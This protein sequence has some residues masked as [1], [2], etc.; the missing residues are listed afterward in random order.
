MSI[1]RGQIQLPG[2]TEVHL[3][4]QVLNAD[5][6]TMPRV[7]LM[8][9]QYPKDSSGT[10]WKSRFDTC[11][12]RLQALKNQY[13]VNFPI[14]GVRIVPKAAAADFMHKLFG[15]TLGSLRAERNRLR[16]S[17]P[18]TAASKIE[19]LEERIRYTLE[20]WGNIPTSDSTP[21]YDPNTETQSIAY[22]FWTAVREFVSN[23]TD[24]VDQIR[25][26]TQCWDVVSR[27]IPQSAKAML[28][29]FDL[30]VFPVELSGGSASGVTLED[31]STHADVV[32]ETC[33]RQVQLAIE[34]MI[35]EPRRELAE[36]LQ[37]VETLIQDRGRLSERT[38]TKVRRAIEK[39]NT[40]SF[41]ANEGLLQKIQQLNTLLDDTVPSR[42]QLDTATA[43]TQA[44]SAAIA[45]IRTE[46][47]DRDLM[48]SDLVAF[49][50]HRRAIF[51]DDDSD[52]EVGAE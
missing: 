5:A 48:A 23:Y 21:V 10:P 6:V 13:S 36:S 12:S 24:I 17:E 26:R 39:L 44:F 31:L 3:D 27:K 15:P 2:K 1:W 22:E 33:A 41:V 49:G 40:F 19:D 9:K 20:L 32:R 30:G 29:K 42:L 25:V 18:Y 14:H 34:S 11:S 7:K 37:N 38:F 8:T 35:M 45:E 16:E 46:I 50:G 28:R 51:L 47:A 43:N 52:A 4:D